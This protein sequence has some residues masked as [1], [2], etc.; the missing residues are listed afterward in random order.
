VKIGYG[1]LGRSMPLTLAKCGN[2]GGDVEMVAVVKQLALRHPEDDF[3][4]LGRNSGED[5]LSVG[6]PSNVYNPWMIWAPILRANLNAAGLNQA[7]LSV[8]QHLKVRDIFDELTM[9][10]FV[11]MDAH[12]WWVGQHGTSNNPLPRVDDPGLL[13][14]PYDWCAYYAGYVLRGINAWRELHGPTNHEEVWLNADSRNRHKMRDLKFP[15]Q[16]PVLT[17][18]TFSHPLKHEQY[19]GQLPIVAMCDNVYARL[20]VNGLAP[21]TPFGDLLS[22]NNEW[23]GRSDF[24][25]F[26]NEARRDVRE[27]VA[28]RTVLRDWV[29]PLNPAFVHGTW[30]ERSQTE[31]GFEIKPVPWENYVP[32]LQSVRCTFTTP[33]SGSGFATA[34]P[35]E[36]FAA[37][38]VCFFHPAYD[39]QGN[40]LVD[41]PGLLK[42]WLPI[43]SPADLRERFTRVSS[44]PELWYDLVMEQRRHFDTE[45][46]NPMWLNMV[47]ERVWKA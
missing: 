18:Q 42:T 30:S 46:A 25:L 32:T 9:Q 1:K 21:G 16:R 22:F 6:L 15:L 27:A 12:V 45:M 29:L 47:E 39:T 17:Q 23:H 19:D 33:S 44:D 7:N 36:A 5:P 43:F 4:L 20:E 10:R 34:K 2:L 37:G 38:T 28:R 11:E 3:Y 13:T 8:E 40:I 14:K 24:G 26:I 31:L 41:A 35:W